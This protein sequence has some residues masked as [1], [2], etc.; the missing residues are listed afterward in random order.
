MNLV[1]SD[2]VLLI[3]IGALCLI[4]IT[5]TILKRCPGRLGRWGRASLQWQRGN[6][7]V[8]A[9]PFDEHDADQIFYHLFMKA[10]VGIIIADL[11]GI[12]KFCN[13]LAHQLIN[14]RATP[15][16]GQ[17]LIQLTAPDSQAALAQMVAQVQ[18]QHK[19]QPMDAQDGVTPEQA[20]DLEPLEIRLQPLVPAKQTG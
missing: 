4:L 19:N 17:N 7:Q 10:P 3:V 6:Q 8:D 12:I 15:V 11:A 2:I 20:V 13:P 9:K 18:E 14:D 5:P 16:L 1:L